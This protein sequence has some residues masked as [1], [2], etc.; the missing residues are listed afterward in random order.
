MFSLR[1]IESFFNFVSRVVD[2]MALDPI[3]RQQS[4]HL[5]LN[6][7]QKPIAAVP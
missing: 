1:G 6:D 4:S 5:S 3:F 2:E 7:V